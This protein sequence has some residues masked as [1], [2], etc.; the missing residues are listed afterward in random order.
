MSRSFVPT[1]ETVAVHL[2]VEPAT[3]KTQSLNA[4]FKPTVAQ[5]EWHNA[6]EKAEVKRFQALLDVVKSNLKSP[7]VFRVGKAEIE[8]YVVGQVADGYA[9]FKTMVVET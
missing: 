3:I 6:E 1:A 4:F 7:K 5:E 9:G 8:V 2:K